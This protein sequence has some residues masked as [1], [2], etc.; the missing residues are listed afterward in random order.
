[1]SEGRSDRQSDDESQNS[2]FYISHALVCQHINSCTA[3]SLWGFWVGSSAVALLQ[4]CASLAKE[5]YKMVKKMGTMG[6]AEEAFPWNNGRGAGLGVD[7]K[8]FQLSI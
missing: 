4:N 2:L 6:G 1:M 8:V 7:P 3:P 5:I